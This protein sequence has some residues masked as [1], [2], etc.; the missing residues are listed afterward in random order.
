MGRL[1][2]TSLANN[3]DDII[4][5][6]RQ[7]ERLV[8]IAKSYGFTTHAVISKHL[9][10]DTEYQA[11][12][13]DGLAARMDMREDEL[14]LAEDSVTVARARELLSHARWRAEHECKRWQIKQADIVINTGVSIDQALASNAQAILDRLRTV[15]T[16]GQEGGGV[17]G[18]PSTGAVDCGE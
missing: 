13:E 3:R 5:R 10:D 8:D 2:G 6:V 11:A 12:K 18:M 16:Q 7:G 1:P 9:A 15:S 4:E 17:G 14:A